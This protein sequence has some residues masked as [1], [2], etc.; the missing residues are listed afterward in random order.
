MNRFLAVCLLLPALVF[1]VVAQDVVGT[2]GKDPV[3]IFRI[4]L[5][6]DD[7]LR[8]WEDADLVPKREA[9][10]TQDP[11]VLTELMAWHG[12]KPGAALPEAELESRLEQLRQT[13]EDSRLYY[14]VQAYVIPPQK[15]PSRRTLFLAVSSGFSLRFGGG[16]AWGMFGNDNADGAWLGYRLFAGYNLAGGTIGQG[17]PGISPFY[18]QTG[19]LYGNNGLE[20]EAATAFRHDGNWIGMAGISLRPFQMELGASAAGHWQ[21]DGQSFGE[22]T[23][24]PR[25]G[26]SGQTR[27]SELILAGSAWLRAD[28]AA[29]LPEMQIADRWTARLRGK[30]GWSGLMLALQGAA[31]VVPGCA[32]QRYQFNLGG[33]PDLGVRADWSE[34]EATVNHYLMLNSEL[35]WRVLNT[36]LGFISAFSLEPFIFLDLAVAGQGLLDPT[37]DGGLAA[38]QS[39][40]RKLSATGLGLRIL[41]G[42][43]VFTDFTVGVGCAPFSGGVVETWRWKFVFSVSAGF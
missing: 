17:L 8:L 40:E 39:W 28:V 20:P 34:R 38:S 1:D 30:L 14:Q 11:A 10:M 12:L 9:G 4:K 18:W 6:I 16:G 41:L 32:I 21:T 13:L 15:D 43:P 2:S 22:L 29:L 7:Q 19:L 37:L 42:L 25:I 36:P 23:L 24:S 35:R 27:V 31:G 33:D 26:V 5:Q 3:I